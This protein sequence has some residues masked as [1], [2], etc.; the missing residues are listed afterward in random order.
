M[1]KPNMYRALPNS[2]R[3]ARRLGS[4]S[5]TPF[6][7]SRLASPRLSSAQLHYII[8]KIGVDSVEVVEE[9]TEPF[10]LLLILLAVAT[11]ELLPQ[12][13]DKDA[14]G[15]FIIK[16]VYSSRLVD[17]YASK[18]RKDV[19]SDG[20][21]GQSLLMDIEKPLDPQELRQLMTDGSE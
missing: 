17:G 20:F 8:R 11:V 21:A 18:D 15:C 3:D 4:L 6:V 1:F 5:S 16:P 19:D 7:S 12:N 14:M 9:F 10:G 2:V 13:P